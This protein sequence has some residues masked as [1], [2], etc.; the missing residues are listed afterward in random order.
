[1]SNFVVAWDESGNIARTFNY[2]FP[3]PPTWDN[4]IGSMSGAVNDAA[5]N[6]QSAYITSGYVSG[7]LGM[8]VVTVSGPTLRVYYSSDVRAVSVSWT[9]QATFT[10]SDS[11]VTSEAR[12]ASSK[13]QTGF[14]IV[15]W[16]DG[17]GTQI[18]RTTDGA[19]WSSAVRVGSAITDVA[20]NNNKPIG[21]AVDGMKQL[22]TAPDNTGKY[23]LYLATSTGGSFSKVT[24]SVN[25][26]EPYPAVTIDS[27][28][29]AYVGLLSVGASEPLP[30]LEWSHIEQWIVDSW[31]GVD[32]IAGAWVYQAGYT[33]YAGSPN[34]VTIE[35]PY[36]ILLMGLD[37]SLGHG[38]GSPPVPTLHIT[39][40]AT[41]E[42]IDIT[43][44]AFGS[45]HYNWE[46]VEWPQ[47]SEGLRL[48][49][50]SSGTAGGAFQQAGFSGYGPEIPNL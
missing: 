1:M 46:A 39:D 32:I 17:T 9:L 20:N 38:S 43:P 14:A 29:K 31:S 37:Y 41:N 27:L 10:M 28:G 2:L 11:T 48:S 12:I 42:T 22:I 47:G 23:F 33:T 50:S 49:I 3:A 19:N 40:L 45:Y 34:L 15:A 30:E 36:S 5:Y 8:Y 35:I 7:A 44:E 18:A 13:T 6:W 16:K 24:G 4:I 26:D 21:L 25:S